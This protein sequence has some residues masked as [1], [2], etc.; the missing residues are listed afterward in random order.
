[1]YASQH[2]FEQDSFAQ[3]LPGF[4]MVMDKFSGTP[5]ANVAAHYAGICCLY[6]GDYQRAVDFFGRYDATEG[7]A[8]IVLTAQNLGLT[9]DA[10]VQMNDLARGAEFYAKAASSSDNGDTAPY[11]LKKAGLVNE[12]LGNNDLALEQYSTIRDMYPQSFVARDIDKF[13]AHVQQLQGK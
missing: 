2:L 7:A 1:M 6:N 11:Y 13:I 12:A 5:Q 3:A 10:Y 9:G 4:E 8:G